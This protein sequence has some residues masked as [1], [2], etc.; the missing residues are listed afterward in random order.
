[1]TIKTISRAVLLAGSLFILSNAQAARI[2]S[3]TS[4]IGGTLVDFEGQSDG[5]LVG[6]GVY[7][8]LTFSQPDGGRP[9]IDNLPYLFGYGASSGTG[10][11][12]GSTEGGAPFPTIAG[13]I[14]SFSTGQ[15]AVEAFFSD[16]APL[17]GYTVFAY[18]A[19]NN[20][21]DSFVISAPQRYVG[22][23]NLSEAIFKIQFGP[24]AAANDAFAIDDLRYVAAPV[25]GVPEPAT[26]AM[27][28]GGFA[29]AG[30][31][32]RRRKS[33]VSFA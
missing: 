33:A 19:T 24:G 32:M 28:I 18:G 17:G 4:T 15:S 11:L 6:A 31:A 29:L 22:F 2:D 21:L 1:M 23:S 30:S 9:Q 25:R 8:G 26:W 5:T 10:V 13:L 20:L 27:M 12:T 3:A 14:V 7:A 16:T